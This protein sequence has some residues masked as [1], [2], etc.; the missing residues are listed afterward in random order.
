[1]KE[2]AFGTT[3][4]SPR[5]QGQKVNMQQNAAQLAKAKMRA[6]RLADTL[7]REEARPDAAARRHQ[8]MLEE[9]L[10]PTVG[11]ERHRRSE[12]SAEEKRKQER[13]KRKNLWEQ[14]PDCFQDIGDRKR[15]TFNGW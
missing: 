4:S 9:R 1:M 6:A 12:V 8:K 15:P 5:E 3:S 7:L 13:E 11:L 10:G 14:A 2:W